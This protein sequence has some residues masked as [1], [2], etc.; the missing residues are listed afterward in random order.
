MAH[1][2]GKKTMQFELPKF[3]KGNRVKTKDGEGEIEAISNEGNLGYFYLINGKFY[4]QYEI[5]Q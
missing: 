3:K 5:F 1:K 4:A 2:S